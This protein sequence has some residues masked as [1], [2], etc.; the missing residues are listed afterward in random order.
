MLAK[1]FMMRSSLPPRPS[2][3]KA[4]IKHLS[5]RAVQQ[6]WTTHV[7]GPQEPG[8]LT[9]PQHARLR[10]E[11]RLTFGRVLARYWV[12]VAKEMTTRQF[13]GPCL[14]SISTLTGTALH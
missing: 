10:N 7:Q 11:F 2:E 6:E 5:V 13:S 3:E 8:C 14:R 12:A 4:P 9:T 1:I